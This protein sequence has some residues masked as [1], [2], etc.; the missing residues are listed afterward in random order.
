VLLFFIGKTQKQSPFIFN[1]SLL[2]FN[3]VLKRIDIRTKDQVSPFF[4]RYVIRR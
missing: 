2:L 3:F 4:F 1:F